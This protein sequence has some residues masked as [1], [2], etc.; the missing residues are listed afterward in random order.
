MTGFFIPPEP[1]FPKYS[2]HESETPGEHYIIHFEYP[3]FVA[4]ASKFHNDKEEWLQTLNEDYLSM[5]VVC[6]EINYLLSPLLTSKDIK[7]LK[8]THLDKARAALK[9]MAE[10]YTAYLEE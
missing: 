2:I 8:E 9:A 10:F 5:P 7:E 4:R 6:N 3:Q 1:P